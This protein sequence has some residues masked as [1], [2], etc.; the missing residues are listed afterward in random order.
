MNGSYLWIGPP[1]KNGFYYDVYMG[2]EHVVPD[3]F[4]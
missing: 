4:E 2:D 1:L 3:Q